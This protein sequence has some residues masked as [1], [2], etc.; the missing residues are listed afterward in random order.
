MTVETFWY[1]ALGLYLF[2][3]TASAALITA[4]V[5]SVWRHLK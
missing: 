4:L 1:V 2:W 3:L 5:I